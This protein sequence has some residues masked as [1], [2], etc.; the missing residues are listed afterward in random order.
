M[1]EKEDY[2]SAAINALISTLPSLESQKFYPK[3][4]KPF[5]DLA[6][7]TPANVDGDDDTN[8]NDSD[9]SCLSLGEKADWFVK[10][11]EKTPSGLMMS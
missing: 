3:R 2:E 1:G 9:L 7:T 8:G 4:L 6:T 5:F 11:P 10:K